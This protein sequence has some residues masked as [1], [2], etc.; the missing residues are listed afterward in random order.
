MIEDQPSEPNNAPN[1]GAS[2]VAR[3]M[4]DNASPEDHAACARWRLVTDANEA[5]Y[6]RARQAWAA[7][8]AA[9]D[10]LSERSPRPSINKFMIA[11]IA[12]AAVSM[13]TVFVL[14]VVA[15]SPSSRIE[16]YASRSAEPVSVKLSSGDSL[17]LNARAQLTVE[18][19]SDLTTVRLANGEA[20]FEVVPGTPRTFVVETKLATIMV[21]GTAFEV[22]QFDQFT[23]ISVQRGSVRVTSREA[24]AEARQLLPGARV[25]VLPDGSLRDLGD[26]PPEIVGAWR[27]GSIVFLDEPISLVFERLQNYVGT[28]IVLSPGIDPNLRVSAT[29]AD[30]DVAS[31]LAS[32]DASLPVAVEW[33]AS[34]EV[35][36]TAD[37]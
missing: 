20:F 18:E 2:W 9:K 28:K 33:K 32:L 13:A 24:G 3:L 15:P 36:V 6:Q 27:T 35:H 37:Q 7:S 34:G 31:V 25:L 29:F 21:T 4:S 22:G 23:S 8:S 10:R 12:A 11:G 19:S 26:I 14:G 1:D 16:S 5:D 30:R 17:I